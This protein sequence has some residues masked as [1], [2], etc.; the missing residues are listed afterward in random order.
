MEPDT[1]RFVL[2]VLLGVSYSSM[3]W[4]ATRWKWM[5]VPTGIFTGLG[6]IVL[7]GT[8]LGSL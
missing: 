2:G 7:I 5:W 6:L 1:A 4:A 3:C 8:A